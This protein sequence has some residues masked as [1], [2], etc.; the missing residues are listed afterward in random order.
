MGRKEVAGIW[1]ELKIIGAKHQTIPNESVLEIAKDLRDSP[2]SRTS[3]LNV[4][5]KLQ[6][7]GF[8][9]GSLHSGG[10][11]LLAQLMKKPLGFKM[12]IQNDGWF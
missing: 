2:F 11:K 10:C 7:S 5:P 4:K 8:A 3:S 6:C 1:S 12:Y 9:Q